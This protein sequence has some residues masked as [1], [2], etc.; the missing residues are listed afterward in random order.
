[1]SLSILTIFISSNLLIQEILIVLDINTQQILN[2]WAGK[3]LLES[4]KHCILHTYSSRQLHSI[5]LA[6]TFKGI[7]LINYHLYGF[8]LF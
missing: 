3:F 8:E 1:M 5:I 4:L 6:Y 7:Y 2:G